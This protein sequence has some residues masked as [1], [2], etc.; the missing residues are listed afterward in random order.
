MTKKL[1]AILIAVILVPSTV[2]FISLA[3]NPQNLNASALTLQCAI[4]YAL[5]NSPTISTNETKWKIA[6][7]ALKEAKKAQSDAKK[8]DN[9]QPSNLTNDPVVDNYSP[10]VESLDNE[11]PDGE[12]LAD[13]LIEEEISPP[14]VT[15]PP[16]ETPTPTASSFENDKIIEGYNVRLAETSV[17]LAKKTLEQSKQQLEAK[18]QSDYYSYKN[19]LQKGEKAVGI[20]A[21]AENNLNLL[22]TRYELGMAT[23]LEVLQAKLSR[24][25][26]IADKNLTDRTAEQARRA[27][28]MTLN[29]PLTTSITLT[30]TVTEISCPR[31]DLN[32]KLDE[33]V[34][35]RMEC[36][37][38]KEQVANDRLLFD[39]TKNWYDSDSSRYQ[40]AKSQLQISNN[41]LEILQEQVKSSVYKAYDDM[42]TAYEALPLLKESESLAERTYEITKV[43]VEGGMATGSDLQDA[44]NK[45][46]D[47]QI[48]TAAGILSYN[49]A[50]INFENSYQI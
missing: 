48:N 14:E 50:V 4:D 43:K 44:L 35:N 3:K 47:A 15:P 7:A 23:Q 37:S 12:I 21:L 34:K 11:L 32:K 31:V 1:V 9:S 5:A 30:D 13:E 16:V 20:L 29:I 25:R 2:A 8:L 27:L 19:A 41:N 40:Q 38:A 45:L 28:C 39:I 24:D 46:Q 26:A 33:A 42:N 6:E 49:L 18:V 17:L 10:A 36:I 22:D